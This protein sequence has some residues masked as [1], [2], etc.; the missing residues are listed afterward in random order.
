MNTKTRDMHPSAAF[1][2][3]GAAGGSNEGTFGGAA[4]RPRGGTKHVQLASVR[5]ARMR[6]LSAAR[7]WEN[8]R[9]G[10]LLCAYCTELSALG[11][12]RNRYLRLI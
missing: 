12:S 8:A 7:T 11:T 3:G 2:V 1:G 4:A 9:G 5:D 6:T 10:G